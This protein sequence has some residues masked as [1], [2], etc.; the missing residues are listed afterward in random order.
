MISNYLLYFTFPFN[1]D[2]KLKK[3]D[4]CRECRNGCGI[5]TTAGKGD[6]PGFHQYSFDTI[7]E[8]H[9]RKIMFLRLKRD[10]NKMKQTSISMLQSWRANCDVALIVYDNDPVKLNAGD[11]ARIS[12]YVVSYATKGNKS[13]QSERDSIAALIENAGTDFVGD[14]KGEVLRLSRKIMN[15]FITSRVVSKAEACVELLSLDLYW[16]T[17]SMRH[18]NLSSFR[19]L[20]SQDESESDNVAAYALR[21]ERI[22]VSM[23]D[24]LI[25]LS[26]KKKIKIPTTSTDIYR[27]RPLQPGLR[28]EIII[29]TGLNGNPV[30]PVSSSYA[31]T[32]L[33]LHKPWSKSN[34]LGF[35][36]GGMVGLFPEFYQFLKSDLCPLNVRL[37]YASAKE[38]YDRGLRFLEV[39]NDNG[40]SSSGDDSNV[41]DPDLLMYVDALR[42]V[43]NFKGME[44]FY[45]GNDG[46]DFSVQHS[47]MDPTNQ[48]GT[49]V[50]NEKNKLLDI[51]E[52]K[53]SH[54]INGKTG[55]PYSVQDLGDNMEQQDIFFE[56]VKTL[57]D[58]LEWPEKHKKNEC[59]TFKPL[60]MTV[61]GAGGTGKSHVIHIITNA[62]ESIFP[63]KVTQT[64]APT[65]CAAYSIGG[66]TVHSFFKVSIKNPGADLSPAKALQM[67]EDV[68][69]LL[70]MII[71]ERSLLSMDA[72]GAAERNCTNNAHGGVNRDKDWGGVPIVL[73]FGDDYQLPSVVIDKEGYGATRV[74]ADNGMLNIA[75]NKIQKAGRDVFLRLTSVVRTL[76]R[77][78]RIQTGDIQLQTF[79][80]AIR[81]KGGLTDTQAEELLNLKINNP[82]ISDARRQ[83]LLHEAIWIF[84]T[85]AEAKEHNK[86]LMTHYVDTTNPLMNFGYKLV[87]SAQSKKNKGFFSHFEIR[88]RNNASVPLCRGARVSLDR[89]IWTEVGLYNGAMGTVIDI[90]FAPGESPLQGH[91]PIYVIVK[92]DE[93]V[94]P[95]WD[96]KNPDHV[97]I[98]PMKNQC[99]TFCCEMEVVPLQLSFARTLH[100]FQGVS[101]G[102]G[103]PIKSMVFD[104]GTT[105]FE[106]NN[107]G[108]LYTG[109]S[110]ATTL[111]NGCVDNSSFYLAGPS[112]TKDRLTNLTQIRAKGRQ[113]KTYLAVLR[114]QQWVEYLKNAELESKLF[115][116]ATPSALKSWL[117]NK[118]PVTLTELD[119]I[120]QYHNINRI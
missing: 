100:K 111:G 70:C 75:L 116:A 38:K 23:N 95:I 87:P 44:D 16:C 97:P 115:P 94:G 57:R 65:G 45:K 105:G 6:T 89:N 47:E 39:T 58:W 54:T 85:N 64:C 30:F 107:P 68:L 43:R 96:E 104:P 49:W 62:I 2:S 81:Y 52:T 8:D 67:K 76:T 74:I 120:I 13:Y 86:R 98:P 15:M 3:E 35:E 25:Q 101:V 69:R 22:N 110:R 28:P 29:P 56:V 27:I 1:R 12:G 83:Q 92:F 14:Q 48:D 51:E 114:R 66:K 84:T 99:N 117:K 91:L 33:L 63:V 17:E 106:G 7:E 119:S 82:A 93:Y 18:V 32:V 37:D 24:F 21:K 41:D 108:I 78:Q 59:E 42:N 77:S 9:A 10:E 61:Q 4:R 55:R 46:F 5:E 118:E 79:S 88:T 103:H 36:S 112:A 50:Q 102:P 26:A 34:P 71:D 40:K 113:K 73:L 19:R 53:K 60:F 11:I 80:D 109:I 31:R 72:L 20:K 90:R